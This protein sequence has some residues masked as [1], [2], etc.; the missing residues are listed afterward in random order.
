MK[1]HVIIFAAALLCAACG[2]DNKSDPEKSSACDI[3]TFT[4]G[5]GVWQISG[6]SITC[7]FPKETVQGNLAPVIVVS[8]KATVNP[9]SGTPQNFFTAQGVPY[10]V[11]AED[12]KTKK[13][14]TAKADVALP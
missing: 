4:A 5:D 14:Y 13:T 3:L 7:T 6:N 8:E 11:T 10:T 1:K 9:P 12:G 2:K